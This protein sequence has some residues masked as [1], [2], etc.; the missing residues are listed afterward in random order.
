MKNIS[1]QSESDHTIYGLARELH[2]QERAVIDFS[3]PVNPLGVSKKVKA[4]IRKHL[5]YLHNYPDPEAGRLR[6]RLAQ[7]HGIDP[8]MILC[9][10]GSTELIYLIIRAL[11]P[12]KVLVTAP[13]YSEYY[14]VVRI[15][16]RVQVSSFKLQKEKNFT[17]DPDALIHAVEGES[18]C[19]MV[20]LCNPNNP[21]GRLVKRV[22]V[23]RIAD[24]AK[25]LKCYLIVDETFIDYC[26]DNSVIGDI[27]ENP[28]LIVLRTM[29]S[30]YALPGLRI[31]Y[32]VLPL[33]LREKMMTYK[34]PWTV[35]SLAQ[36]A[37]VV[38]LKDKVYTK[39]SF[40]VMQ[41]EKRFLEKSF[42]KL[43]VAFIPSDANFYLIQLSIS[44]EII[45][46]LRGKG[47]LVGGCSGIPGLDDT[48]LRVAVKSH[49]ENAT[50]IKELTK[51][52]DSTG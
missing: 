40:Q 35:N 44:I 30:F 33:H 2:I 42:R 5:K 15:S 49:R 26:P 31:G 52:L 28:Y 37:A 17:I 21:T 3:N 13:T 12:Q 29:S 47:I 51:I 19:D 7:F 43:G 11:Q 23:N 39:E 32:G 24:A 38:A 48:Y 14:R 36:R 6:K 45:R 22:D 34:E 46:R 25:A 4:E 8:E 27:A 20:F 50:L 41:Q 16:Y 18:S 10:N 9:G 1:S